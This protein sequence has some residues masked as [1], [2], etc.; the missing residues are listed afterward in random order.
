MGRTGTRAS[1]APKRVAT[2]LRIQSR[3]TLW[4]D[5]LLKVL[6]VGGFILFAALAM[7]DDLSFV[8]R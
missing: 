4:R 5:L 8:F 7:V 3:P 6:V 1:N 2:M